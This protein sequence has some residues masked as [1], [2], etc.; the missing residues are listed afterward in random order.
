MDF[1]TLSETIFREIFH[2]CATNVRIYI[3][4]FIAVKE[5]A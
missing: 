5:F 4:I 2:L 3:C 1:P